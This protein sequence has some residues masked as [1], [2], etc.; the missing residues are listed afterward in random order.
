MASSRRKSTR[1]SPGRRKKSRPSP[2]KPKA[3]P[4][5]AVPPEVRQEILRQVASG[6]KAIDVAKQY[7]VHNTTISRWKA[8]ERSR[9]EPPGSPP[10]EPKEHQSPKPPPRETGRYTQ[11]F[12]ED[13]LRQVQSGRK[14]VEVARQY[15]VPEKTLC[16]GKK[17]T[18]T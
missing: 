12:K 17:S 11:A 9:K 15:R 3:R 8:E 13:V 18:Q 7:G 14:L 2:R 1:R 16:D 6:R 4:R 5:G 10:P